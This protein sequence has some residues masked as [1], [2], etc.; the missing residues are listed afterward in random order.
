MNYS[1]DDPSI[2]I[3]NGQKVK[4]FVCEKHYNNLNNDQKELNNF[5][6]A[7]KIIE[8]I[9][10]SPYECLCLSFR[11]IDDVGVVVCLECGERYA[12]IARRNKNSNEVIFKI[13]K[14]FGK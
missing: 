2:F 4:Y 8:V 10:L 14:T 9:E 3:V 11:A 13:N 5:I 7:H 12:L 1:F 6:R